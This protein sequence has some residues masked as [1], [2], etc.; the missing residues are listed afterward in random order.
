[1]KRG[2][3][4]ILLFLPLLGVSQEGESKNKEHRFYITWGYNRAFYEESDIHFK[5]DGFDFTLYDVQA[6][7]L[8]EPFDTKVYLN[9]TKLTIPQFD[10]RIGYY[11]N[12]KTAISG[13]W[14]HMKYRIIP[15]QRAMIDGYMS[16]E[17]FGHYE[18]EY[19]EEYIQIRPDLMQYEH[20]DGFNFVRIGLEHYEP[21]WQSK[22][23]KFKGVWYGGI[24]AGLMFPWTDF[25]FV[26]N[27]YRN[28]IHL[29]GW[30]VSA[31]MGGRFEIGKYFFLQGQAQ[32]GC[33]SM[34]DI[35]IQNDAD[36]RA[37]QNIVFFERSWMLGGYVPIGK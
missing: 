13:G 23:Q 33:T 6:Q 2:V 3:L 21:V 30:G 11:L 28:W 22:N 29:S 34:G 15:Y 17:E 5:G 9:P 14:D 1:M 32:Y 26:G 31:L 18:G 8:P 12:E 10:F 37:S 25:H 24:S 27:Y 20:S 35:I 19:N 7:D 36:S 16:G 4:S